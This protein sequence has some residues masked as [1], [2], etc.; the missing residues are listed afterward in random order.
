[1]PKRSKTAQILPMA[2]IKR[3]AKNAVTIPVTVSDP[4]SLKFIRAVEAWTQSPVNVWVERYVTE[5]LRKCA[6][7]VETTFEAE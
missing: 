1:M 6:S 3:R 5:L 2:E 7:E 4:D